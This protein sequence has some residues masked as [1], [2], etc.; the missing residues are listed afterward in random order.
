MKTSKTSS[1]LQFASIVGVIY[2][3][4]DLYKTMAKAQ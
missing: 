1:L 4:N 3:I 2:I